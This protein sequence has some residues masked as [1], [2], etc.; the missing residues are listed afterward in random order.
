MLRDRPFSVKHLRVSWFNCSQQ[1]S[2][3]PPIPY[4]P[5]LLPSTVGWGRLKRVKVRELMS[6]SKDSW[7]EQYRKKKKKKKD[8]NSVIIKQ[9][10]YTKR[11]MHKASAHQVMP[12]QSL[13]STPWPALPPA[14]ILSM[15]LYGLEYPFAQL[16]SWT[17]GLCPLTTSGAPPAISLAGDDRLESPWLTVDTT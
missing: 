14:D 6:C 13:S 2:T 16:R 1:L 11:V 8:S 3:T 17:L 4:F 12:S 7:M 9:V 10:K 5:L 15:M